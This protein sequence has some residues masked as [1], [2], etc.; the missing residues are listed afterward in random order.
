MGGSVSERQR[1][2]QRESGSEWHMA[3]S[4]KKGKSGMK[5]KPGLAR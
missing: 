5:P 3:F 2:R 1:K 4:L